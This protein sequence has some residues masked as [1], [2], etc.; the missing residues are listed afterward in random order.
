MFI[1]FVYTYDGV[2]ISNNIKVFELNRDFFSTFADSMF[3]Y[4]CHSLVLP[5]RSELKRSS[6]ERMNKICTR[7]VMLTLSCYLLLTITGYLT[8]LNIT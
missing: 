3:C 2:K 4:I 7:A 5:L 6:V 8:W 1:Y